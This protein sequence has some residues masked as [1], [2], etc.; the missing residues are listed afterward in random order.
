MCNRS[1][2]VGPEQW[3][4]MVYVKANWTSILTSVISAQLHRKSLTL[5]SARV[6]PTSDNPSDFNASLPLK[7]SPVGL[8][9]REGPVNMENGP[10]TMKYEP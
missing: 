9:P 5:V 10:K 8:R 1:T 4:Y 2:K 6:I 3:F 7:N